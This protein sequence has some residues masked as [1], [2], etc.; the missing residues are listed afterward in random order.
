MFLNSHAYSSN[1]I[2]HAYGI[3]TTPGSSSNYGKL[4]LQVLKYSPTCYYLL[5]LKLNTIDLFV[6]CSII[7]KFRSFGQSNLNRQALKI[8]VRQSN[9]LKIVKDFNENLLKRSVRKN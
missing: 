6:C 9:S 2:Y 1:T 5:F 3:F 4:N 8:I 7:P